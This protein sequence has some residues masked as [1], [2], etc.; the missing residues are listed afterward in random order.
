MVNCL[1]LYHHTIT[2]F[3]K[4]FILRAMFN[5]EDFEIHVSGNNTVSIYLWNVERAEV[6]QAAMDFE[7]T[8]IMT[9]YGYGKRKKDAEKAA[10][11][12][13]FKRIAEEEKG[14]H[15]KEETETYKLAY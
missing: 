15:V 12:V 13:L 1:I 7:S 5:S 14:F 9:G 2:S 4:C 8:N 11:K 10:T 3:T 6:W